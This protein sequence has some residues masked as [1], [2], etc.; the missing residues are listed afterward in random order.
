MPAIW[1]KNGGVGDLRHELRKYVE[2]AVEWESRAAFS[3]GNRGIFLRY[4]RLFIVEL[5]R[6]TTQSEPG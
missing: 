3:E 2:H 1:S 5:I 4:C 6:I